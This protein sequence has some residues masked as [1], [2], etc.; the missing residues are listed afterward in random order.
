MAITRNG[1]AYNLY[2]SPYVLT[3]GCTSYYF[4][5]LNHMDKFTEQLSDN[6]KALSYSLY[7]RFKIWVF[8]NKL[9]DIVLYGKVETRGFLIKHKG[10]YYECLD[11]IIL[12][13]ENKISKKSV[14]P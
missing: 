9:Y 1:I 7:K 11:N 13:G 3:D 12:S 5:S 10:D 2:E 4:S 14:T 8:C 6:R